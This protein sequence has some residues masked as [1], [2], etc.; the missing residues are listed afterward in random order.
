MVGAG[1]F[2][3]LGTALIGL[4]IGSTSDS[5]SVSSS[6]VRRTLVDGSGSWI[7]LPMERRLGYD[8]G[9]Q[10]WTRV[11]RTLEGYKDIAA[12]NRENDGVYWADLNIGS[13]A[14]TFSVIVDTGS[15]TIAVP[16]SGCGQCGKHNKFLIKDGARKSGGTYNQC[17]SEGSCN[18]GSRVEATMCLGAGCDAAK[19][20]TKHIFGCCTTYARAFQNQEADGIIGM[21]GSSGTLVADLRMHHKLEKDMF[22]MCLSAHVGV[23]GVGGYDETRHMEPLQWTAMQDS[24]FYYIKASNFFVGSERVSLGGIRSPFVDSGTTFTYIPTNVHNSMKIAFDK[25][26]NAKSGRCPGEKGTKEAMREDLRDA[27]ACYKPPAALVN[28]LQDWLEQFPPLELELPRHDGGA[29]MKVCIPSSTYFFRSQKN[30]YCVGLLKGGSKFILG[31]ITMAGF[32]MVFDHEKK[33]LGFARAIC[34]KKNMYDPSYRTSPSS[35]CGSCAIAQ[36][37]KFNENSFT[38]PAG[39]NETQSTPISPPTSAL[40]SPPT[41]PPSPNS[42]VAETAAPTASPTDS[43]T[44]RPTLPS[45]GTTEDGLFTYVPGPDGKG[46]IYRPIM[47]SAWTAGKR[48]FGENDILEIDFGHR[49]STAGRASEIRLCADPSTPDA[50]TFAASALILVR[51][52]GEVRLGQHCTFTN[53]QIGA[54]AKCSTVASETITKH[55][56]SAPVTIKGAFKLGGL[57]SLRPH[58]HLALDHDLA[59]LTTIGNRATLVIEPGAT[60]TCNPLYDHKSNHVMLEHGTEHTF[61]APGKTHCYTV[62]GE[63]AALSIVPDSDTRQAFECDASLHMFGTLTMLIERNPFQS[64]GLRMSEPIIWNIE[65]GREVPTVFRIQLDDEVDPDQAGGTSVTDL[66]MVARLVD[67]PWQDN[68]HALEFG[69]DLECA[70]A[71]YDTLDLGQIHLPSPRCLAK[72]IADKNMPKTPCT[73]SERLW[74]AWPPAKNKSQESPATPASNFPSFSSGE[75]SLLTQGI[76]KFDNSTLSQYYG[77][78]LQKIGVESNPTVQHSTLGGFFSGALVAVVVIIAIYPPQCLRAL[79]RVMC[80]CCLPRSNTQNYEAVSY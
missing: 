63:K 38:S 80:A 56:T 10:R 19:E 62:V 57:L 20:G 17:Y 15:S 27:I 47:G 48:A 6:V 74:E 79:C 64:W 30:A 41:S 76:D 67:A 12:I 40:T 14:Q 29:P 50:W 65:V 39:N 21:S 69:P 66:P 37:G 2:A 59:N 45:S 31:A 52:D 77:D 44:K 28:N 75:G 9:P 61:M 26:C 23:L 22:S 72:C 46:T 73:P 5:D 25:W 1:R 3:L 71:K 68:P 16:C 33:R 4:V 8:R 13:P 58:T 53:V 32:D 70:G 55:G 24:D 43:P 60:L 54:E 7:E 11:E 42:T 35:C 18:R 51:G 34:E 49:R 78:F 36:A